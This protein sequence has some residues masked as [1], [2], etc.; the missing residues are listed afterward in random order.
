MAWPPT[1]HQDAVDEVDTL[2]DGKGWAVTL[3]GRQRLTEPPRPS[4]LLWVVP[5]W[6]HSQLTGLTG[7]IAPT[8]SELRLLPFYVPVPRAI[9]R[10]GCNVTTAGTSGHVARLGIYNASPTT[11]MPTTVFLDAGT[12]AVG[13]TG[14]KEVTLTATL[15]GLYWLGLTAQSGT[16]VSV[17]TAQSALIAGATTAAGSLAFVLNYGSVDPTAALPDRTGVTPVLTS[18]STPVVGVRAV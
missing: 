13:T 5:R 7:T 8:A 4:P 3:G 11:G 12:V 6:Y 15:H 18:T 9:D 2:R 1:T 17:A 16:F 14:V 10:V